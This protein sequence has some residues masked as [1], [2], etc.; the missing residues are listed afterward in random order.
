MVNLKTLLLEK[1]DFAMGTSSSS[2]KLIH[3][4]L[5]YLKNLQFSVVIQS[6]KERGALIKNAPHI[7]KRISFILPFYSHFKRFVFLFGIKLYD[8]L[9]FDYSFSSQS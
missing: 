7:V 9:S 3:G 2:T 6:L 4:G 8:F 5:R 1:D